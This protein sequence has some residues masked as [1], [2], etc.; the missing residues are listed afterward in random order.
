M[1]LW[2]FLAELGAGEVFSAVAGPGAGR[3]GDMAVLG[4]V[5]LGFALGAGTVEG[6]K[7]LARADA[8]ALVGVAAMP[9]LRTLRPRLGAI[10]DRVDA[11]ALQRTFANALVAAGDERAQQVFFVDDHFV[12]YSG[13]RPVAKGWNT[14]RRHAQRGYDN[15]VVVDLAGRAI[16]F[17]SGEPSGLSVTMPPVLDQLRQVSGPD[18]RLL[19]GFDRGGAYPKTFTKLRDAGIDWVT[20]RRAPLVA[21]TGATKVSWFNL[22]GR[23]HTYRIADE[24]VHLADYGQARQVSV[25]EH[26]KVVFQVLTSDTTATAARLVH[27]LRCRWRIEN[28]FK[29][30]TAHHGIDSLCDYTMTIGPDTAAVRNPDRT[31]ALAAL[32]AGEAALAAAQRE[33]GQA[34]ATATGDT[35]Y[36]A[37]IGRLRDKVSS[38]EDDVTDAKTALKAIPAELPANEINPTATRATP[39]S[40][41]RHLQMVL[42]LLAYNAETV[43]AR[44]LNT[45]LTDPDEYRAIT[46]HL[47]HQSGNIHY[48]PTGITVTLDPPNQPRVA[49]ALTLLAD[50][51]NQTTTRMPGDPRHITYQ[52]RVS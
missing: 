50:E 39:R 40:E 26:G 17:D 43:L 12:A 32:R 49:R 2:P 4:A 6:M 14:K 7:H 38:A 47:L 41:R 28:A 25:Y 33:L 42:R 22:D 8:G 19:V 37:T 9:E 52:I 23:R 1:L 20:Y 31:A 27:L 16:C 30:L 15:T 24:T 46:R 35:D 13:A 44:R 34:R 29:Y 18:A 11:L 51:L 10:A 5:T 36:L 21:A 48:T 45:Y 3:Y